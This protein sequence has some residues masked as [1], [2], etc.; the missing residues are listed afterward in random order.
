MGI[1]GVGSVTLMLNVVRGEEGNERGCYKGHGGDGV[2]G[3][4]GEMNV[5]SFCMSSQPQYLVAFSVLLPLKFD[6]DV[7]MTLPMSMA[8]SNDPTPQRRLP[9]MVLMLTRP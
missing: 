9:A 6:D 4:R 1:S 5:R 7:A 8:R 3:I 2:L